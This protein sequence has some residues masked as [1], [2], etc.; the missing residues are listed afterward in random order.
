MNVW[1]VVKSMDFKQLWSLFWLSAR[2]PRFILPTIRGTRR[3]IT[4]CD[5][6]YGDKQHLNGPENAFRHALWNVLLVHFSTQ[7]G[8]PLQRSLAW[9][10][11]ITDWHEDFSPNAALARAMDLHNNRVGRDIIAQFYP[12]EEH[13]FVAHLL[14]MVPLSQ[15]L[16]D[17][18]NTS[19]EK[20]VLVHIDEI[21]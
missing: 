11:K 8:L 15:K 10:K 12:E 16:T 4:I 18:Y 9:A 3:T 2:H 19:L 17:A 14:K 20:D 5:E 6:L 13:F 7:K 21:I 1:A